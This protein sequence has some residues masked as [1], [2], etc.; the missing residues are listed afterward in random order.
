M[1]RAYLNT[2]S[3]LL[4]QSSK[5]IL[6]NM[7]RIDRV[8]FTKNPKTKQTENSVEL[9]I[10]A[11][12]IK[13]LHELYPT[14]SILSEHAG[15]V[16]A[17]EPQSD[18]HFVWILDPI[19]GSAN[20]VNGLP[21]YAVCLSLFENRR[22]VMSLV[23]QPVTDDLFTAT[24]DHGALYNGKKIR[25]KRTQSHHSPVVLLAGHHPF[26][27]VVSELSTVSKHSFDLDQ[28]RSLGS[29]SLSLAY[30]ATGA[31]DVF[32]ARNVSICQAAAGL[33]IASEAGASVKQN[34]SGDIMIDRIMS[35]LSAKS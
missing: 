24:L 34:R 17:V 27:E 35:T 26:H 23:Y 22:C 6:Q 1:F 19:D 18:E 25:A 9:A 31:S 14:H 20:F 11:D 5:Y 4:R 15:L 28:I 16:E 7:D 13:R 32:Y 12:I 33:L 8:K 10:E 21:D 30:H 2:A 29:V 3:T